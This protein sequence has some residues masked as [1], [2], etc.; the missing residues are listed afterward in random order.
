MGFD[1]QVN[2]THVGETSFRNSKKRL[3]CPKK[4]YN[5]RRVQSE[6]DVRPVTGTHE[7]KQR[8]VPAIGKEKVGDKLLVKGSG[9]GKGEYKR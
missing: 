7:L 2:Q 3:K 6:G 8:G 4:K 9:M 5:M 1:P